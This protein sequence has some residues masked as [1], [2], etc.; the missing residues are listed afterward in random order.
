[1]QASAPFSLEIECAE[2]C[3]YNY[4]LPIST[5]QHWICEQWSDAAWSKRCYGPYWERKDNV[6][7]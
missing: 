7:A 1:M 6:R 4:I 5:H 2:M 3:D